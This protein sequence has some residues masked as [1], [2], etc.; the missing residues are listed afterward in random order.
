MTAATSEVQPDDEHI[1][2]VRLRGVLAAAPVPRSLPSGDELTAFR[3]TVRRPPDER[4]HVDSIDCATTTT[5]VRRRLERCAVGDVVELTGT[6]RRRFWRNAGGIGS[7]YE[8]NVAAIRVSRRP[9]RR[10]AG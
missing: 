9:R 3:I 6:L 8:V 2:E 4:G 1:N 10:N 5:T 7:R